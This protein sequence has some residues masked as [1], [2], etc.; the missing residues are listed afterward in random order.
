ME[1]DEVCALCAGNRSVPIWP[2]PDLGSKEGLRVVPVQGAFLRVGLGV[3][4]G[5][6]P[7]QNTQME[8]HPGFCSFVSWGSQ[9]PIYDPP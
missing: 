8:A 6:A 3:R 5:G 1:V 7:S 4:L 9:T 2:N